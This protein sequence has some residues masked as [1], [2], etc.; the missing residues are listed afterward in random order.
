MMRSN[1]ARNFINGAIIKPPRVATKFFQMAIG[2]QK[3]HSFG[4]VRETFN[5]DTQLL[6]LHPSDVVAFL[7]H[8][9]STAFDDHRKAHMQGFADAARAPACR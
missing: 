3:T 9:A 6:L 4:Y 2:E 7:R 5:H 8:G 1:T